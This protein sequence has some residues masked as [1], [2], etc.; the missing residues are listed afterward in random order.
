MEWAQILYTLPLYLTVALAFSY[1]LYALRNRPSPIALPF[2]A[3]ML[4]II[5]WS[6]AYALEL[7]SSSYAYQLFWM[8]FGYFGKFG[9]PVAYLW[10]A[11][12]FAGSKRKF[13][14]HFIPVFF[15]EALLAS[16]LVWTSS[17][18]SLF[19]KS[20]EQVF[21]SPLYLLNVSHGPVFWLQT[22]FTYLL[23]ATGSY[24]LFQDLWNFTPSYRNRFLIIILSV[25]LPILANLLTI[26]QLSPVP[27][28]DL[29]P[30]TFLIIELI[31]LWG[32]IHFH[33]LE[34]MAFAQQTIV[35]N[36]NDAILVVDMLDKVIYSNQAACD[37]LDFS[38]SVIIGK[39]V[40]EAWSD[41]SEL[42]RSASES[43]TSDRPPE[44]I[45][46]REIQ[47]GK[48]ASQRWYRL[49]ISYLNDQ[50]GMRVGKLVIW[51]DITPAKQTDE[52][53]QFGQKRLG[54]LVDNSPN[55]IFSVDRQGK[56]QSWSPACE[57]S[58]QY[59]K[60]IVGQ[61]Y[62]LLLSPADRTV[63]DEKLA[64]VFE[65]GSSIDNI[66][67]EYICKDG[68]TRH[69]ASRLYP[70]LDQS[71][72]IDICILANTDITE[73]KHAQ[74]TLSRQFEELRV[75]HSVAM[76]CVEATNED[77][78]IERV[79]EI[80]GAT[81][82]PDNFGMLMLDE[83]T[84]TVLKHASYRERVDNPHDS[85]P[86]G[87]GITSKAILEGRALRIGDVSLEP[88]YFEVD[89]LTRSELC[90]PLKTSE[91]VIGV[92]NAESTQLNAFDDSDERLLTILAGQLASTI[93]RL[94]TGVAEQLRV[95]ELLAIT[96]ISQEINSLLD[97]QLVL[98][99]IVRYAAE[100]SNSSASGLFL[101]QPDGRLGMVAAYGVDEEFIKL[102]NAE[103]LREEGT[104]V[105]RAIH[106]RQP[107]Q[108]PDL[109]KDLSYSMRPAADTENIQAILALP[110][111][112]GE[113]VIGG[114]VIW[115]RQPH[116]F[117]QE[118]E[119][120]L[121]ALANQSV[122][123]VENARLFE[124]EREQRKMAEVMREAGSRLSSLLN[125]DE[126]LDNL[127]EQL[128]RL[129][130]YDGA[131]VMLVEGGFV[132]VARIRGYEQ[133]DP[134]FVQI[135]R[136]LTLEIS[137]TANLRKMLETLKPLIVSDTSRDPDWIQI[138][139]DY[140]IRSWAGAPI[141]IQGQVAA[142]FSLD[143]ATPG[144]YQPEHAERLLTYS[145]QVGLALQ[146]SRLFEET[147]R[148]L[149]EVTLLSKV[150]ELTA[151]ATSIPSA[152]HQICNEVADFF[153]TRQAAFL[154][155]SHD[156][157]ECEVVAQYPNPSGLRLE[158]SKISLTGLR[159]LVEN[160]IAKR[161]PRVFVD[162]REMFTST[163]LQDIFARTSIASVI[164][165]PFTQQEKVTA[166]LGIA[167]PEPREFS[168]TDYDLMQN[169]SNQ[170]SQSLERLNLFMV[171]QQQAE[172][173]AELA[174]LGGELNRPL[175][176]D[177]VVRGIGQGALAL[178]KAN[179][180]AVYLR[181]AEDTASCAW[182]QGLSAEYVRRVTEQ[183]RDV[184]G[185]QLFRSIEPV[186]VPD[187]EK[188]P[189]GSLL[190]E[191]AQQE[192][193]RAV[194]L[195]PLVYEGKVVAAVGIYYDIPHFWDETQNEILLAF[196]GQS[197]IA[198]QNARLFNETKRRAVQQE[199]LNK[200]IAEVVKAPDLPYLVETVL[201]LTLEAFGSDMGGL[202][203]S[204][205]S[206]LRGLPAS[207]GKAE[208]DMA[209][210]RGIA[211]QD[212]IVINDWQQLDPE[213]N[214]LRGIMEAHQIRASISVPVLSGGKR[215]GGLA[216]ATSEQR[217]WQPDEITLAEAI[218]QQAGSAAERLD[219][220]KQTQ[221]QARQVQ[222]IID[223]VPEG[224]L[225]LD[226][227]H[228][229]I[230]ANPAARKYLSV[231]LG[232]VEI[233]QPLSQLADQ[234][235]ASL[236][237]VSSAQSWRE[238]QA[239]GE[240]N[241]IFEFAAQPLEVAAEKSG[242][243]L[244]LRDITEERANLTRV[245]MQERLAT[246]GQLAAGIAHDFNNIMAAIVVYTDLLAID[247]DLKPEK[248]EHVKIIQQQ[249]QR[250]T[251]LIRQILD[252]SRRSI[253]EPS[254]IDLLPFI[255]ELDKLLGRILPENILLRLS[256]SPGVYMI[257]ADPTSLQQIFM[258]LALNAR[259]AMSAGG[260][261]QFALSRLCIS[262][263]ERPPLPELTPGNWVRLSIS[264]NGVG[265]PESTLTH[266]FD[267][268]YTTKP[269]GKGTGLG[270]AQVYGI[271][272]Q[273]GGSIDVQSVVGEGTTFRLYFPE[274]LVSDEQPKASFPG[275]IPR[276]N[277]ETVLVV[278]DD[279]ATRE[280]LQYLLE[281]QNYNVFTAKD[282][283]EALR[284][285]DQVAQHFDLVV[286][287]I[288]MPGMGGLMLYSA[289]RE[290]EPNIRLLFITG[291]PMEL[292]NQTLLEESRLNWLQKP[293]SMQ[294][295]IS[296][297]RLALLSFS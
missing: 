93:E 1:L 281:S 103:G 296:A 161:S 134:A 190:R 111:L 199:A 234:P 188:L 263:N 142:I 122:N 193:Y 203:L 102:I 100:I 213:T 24:I 99:S 106:L 30:Y 18:Q 156:Y 138:A 29:T 73:R 153:H 101:Y 124:A 110:M 94:R 297:I 184:P 66:D 285:Y 262:E 290:R 51:N 150:I 82:F 44:V 9:L 149:H 4:S 84:N 201:D 143:K 56:I 231:L 136:S 77:A 250:A 165:I 200:I 166:F 132:R 264:D 197:A 283:I 104:A 60:E 42:M 198:I 181:E 96:R 278:E 41:W 179:R 50:G 248:R 246:V 266:I 223:T 230:L 5:V 34:I 251:S 112:R 269:V 255:K 218:G 280:A 160:F 91:R 55:P 177:E 189:A 195:W 157:S 12:E 88:A 25:V 242:W 279:S 236:L 209:R 256:Y 273:H 49:T 225:L 288:V 46:Q 261:L 52:V 107:Y 133:C 53:F 125:F 62:H 131:N 207:L 174:V 23:L 170:V 182:F 258:N 164:L 271:V 57:T 186:L 58:F 28:L 147:Q 215:I 247:P 219:L 67:I 205:F 83:N 21:I 35:E 114:I 194:G 229:V 241:Q 68:S 232:D 224:V 284:L 267:P 47:Q 254:P 105:G 33:F 295:F 292:E 172:Q 228:R 70:L 135:V 10:F 115:N 75:L 7:S 40:V 26:F 227:N 286:S 158:G 173:M 16:I 90:V 2:A 222:M 287:D 27:Y 240:H 36:T 48:N 238:L 274:L 11:Y 226:V 38:K 74:E 141:L 95:Q 152:L 245:Q 260:T 85:M 154:F 6:S 113:E 221:E 148:R 118:E 289:L 126:L 155:L 163:L 32:I 167:I 196:T 249:I 78:L 204:G 217:M 192:Q 162:L 87:V 15:L 72:E 276:G 275:S 117:S 282:G 17:T 116:S 175:T 59:G 243:V 13:L 268:F 206:A 19:F 123:A 81:F 63:L 144:F 294:E 169:I 127:L 239:S 39:R 71:G 139:P 76:A 3:L 253:M 293:F 130:P 252:F 202:W 151:T 8:R 187:T 272:K 146:N 69:M 291:H 120:F 237:E 159:P 210:S 109:A 79:T 270:L 14:K 277:G 211:F 86:L 97:L 257:Q 92:I 65:H 171:T 259:D 220:L 98:N 244:V 183:V 145:S 37:L 185:N 80:I 265:I 64:Q 212:S 137:T 31:I 191:L 129:I 89:G 128:E 168:Q 61:E 45:L 216:I 54:Q 119:R 176:V 121:Q 214:P 233:D 108:I 208:A 235:I 180:A 43:E 140:P 20:I 22:G 178:G